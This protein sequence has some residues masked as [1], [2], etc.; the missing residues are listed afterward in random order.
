[1][2][3]NRDFLLVLAN[4]TPVGPSPSEDELARLEIGFEQ[5]RGEEPTNTGIEQQAGMRMVEAASQASQR[6]RTKKKVPA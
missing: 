1:M 3:N 4:S 6:R 2:P 5:T